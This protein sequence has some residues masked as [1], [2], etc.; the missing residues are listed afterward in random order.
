MERK[1]SATSDRPAL[2]SLERPVPTGG[3]PGSPVSILPTRDDL[4]KQYG[5][6][7]VTVLS[8]DPWTW[9]VY[10]EV[11]QESVGSA[12]ATLEE[13]GRLVLRLVPTSGPESERGG[14]GL[15]ADI[16]LDTLIGRR[17]LE[18]PKL[19]GAFRVAVGLRAESGL[20]MPLAHSDIVQAPPHAPSAETT[21]RWMQVQPPSDERA[22]RAPLLTRSVDPPHD[23]RGV[24]WRVRGERKRRNSVIEYGSLPTRAN[25]PHLDE[26]RPSSANGIKR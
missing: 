20:F 10:W 9:F 4:P 21:V 22:G 14:A 2:S 13:S 7:E 15:P 11:R 17:Y 19:R 16:V 24:P 26:D 8:K 6:D 3:G 23:E 5:V 1:P 18:T 12:R 25:P